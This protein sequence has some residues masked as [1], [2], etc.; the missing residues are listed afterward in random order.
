MRAAE[1]DQKSRGGDGLDET[2]R[3]LPKDSKEFA[4]SR[5]NLRRVLSMTPFETLDDRDLHDE[6]LRKV[7][8]SLESEVGR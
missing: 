4:R 7:L 1:L 3:S 2:L 6:Q 8:R 5:D